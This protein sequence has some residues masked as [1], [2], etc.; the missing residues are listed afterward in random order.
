MPPDI[1]L[2]TLAAKSLGVFWFWVLNRLCQTTNAGLSILCH[3]THDTNMSNY[4]IFTESD[5]I[6]KHVLL[7]DPK[8][9]F[10]PSF[11]AAAEK[12]KFV[13]Q[14]DQPFVLTPLKITESSAA[15][16]ALVAVAASAVAAD[17][18]GTPY[19][20]I[21]V[22]T[23]AATLFL[24]SVL[25]PTIAGKPFHKHE[26]MMPELRK[27]DLY[28]MS[29]P[30]RRLSSNVYRTRDGRWY[31]LHGSLNATPTMQMLGVEE[32]DVST[33]EAIRIYAEKVA[34]W[35]AKDIEKEANDVYNQAGVVCYE[36]EEFLSSEH[37][38][39]ISDEPLWTTTRVPAPRKPWP[40]AKDPDA[41]SPLSGI[42]VIDFSRVIAAPAVSKMLSVLGA[43]VLRVSFDQLPEMSL[44]MPDLQTGKRDTNINLKTEEGRKLFADLVRGADILIDGYRPG[45]LARL[46]FDSHSLRQL[47][48]TLIYM[49]ENC[50]GFKGPLAHRSGWQQ[51][52]DCLVGISHLQGKFLGL[53]EAVV[54]LLP[55]S[56]YQ[57]GLVGAAAAIQALLHRTHEDTTF[58]IDISLT[59]YNIWYY[60]LGLYSEEQ[61]AALR[62]RD[63]QFKPRHYDDIV[64]LVRKTHES[65]VRIRPEM[66][67]HP[68][69]FWIMTAKEYGIDDDFKILAPAFK[70]ATSTV[71]YKVPT[72]R[73]GRSKAEWVD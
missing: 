30:I 33:E 24:E 50:Y 19:Q 71:G 63:L 48:P 27:M 46:G 23:D 36:P 13:G 40:E 17:R 16:N 9:Q 62:S 8:L 37:G 29:V 32:T 39:I 3:P 47:S 2:S 54:P 21:E 64:E 1:G 44:C 38:R 49:R 6:L 41:C 73:R 35:D 34:Q 22:N 51:I 59:Q 26:Q 67:Q 45:V 28:N 57:T 68:E 18:Y 60:R 43:D 20:D 53:D 7:R 11:V 14:D 4:S 52:S 66:F 55:N 70:L 31:H 25:L 61:Q 56:D 58:D 72:G 65:L 15:L 42:R 69:Y 5:R 12:V 10:P